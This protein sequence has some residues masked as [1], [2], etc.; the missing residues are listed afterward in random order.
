M[1]NYQL[2]DTKLVGTAII[3]EVALREAIVNALLHR[4]YS[5][6]GSVKIA[7]YDNRLEIFSPGNFPGLVD[8]N[9]LGDGTTYLRNPNL[10]R[11]A[12]R[13]GII[14]KLGTGI[15]LILESCKKA[16]LKKPE[17]IEGADSVKVIFHFLPDEEKFSLE[18]DKLLALFNMREEVK[19]E[20]VQ[21]YLN[22]S[23]N[24]ATRRLTQLL[25]NGHIKRIGK[26][27]AVRYVK[28]N[29]T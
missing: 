1:H 13:F 23:R 18:E 8:M 29:R 26:G 22:V 21:T 24:T 9:N 12:R 5:I 6:P 2:V 11:N 17:F 28:S 25:E 19:V 27:P 15:R 16:G 14:E 10:A 3:P 7:L 4:K 20:D